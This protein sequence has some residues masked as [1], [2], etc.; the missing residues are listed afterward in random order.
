MHEKS[1]YNELIRDAID[2]HLVEDFAFG[3]IR[4][5]WVYAV[6]YITIVDKITQLY[7]KACNESE[8]KSYWKDPFELVRGEVRFEYGT[9][10]MANIIYGIAEFYEFKYNICMKCPEHGT[11]CGVDDNEVRVCMQRANDK[12]YADLAAPSW[13]D[14]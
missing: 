12:Y 2:Y 5:E 14:D 7:L 1:D 13:N 9:S 10:Y 4:F 8:N 11:Y 3:Y 6:P